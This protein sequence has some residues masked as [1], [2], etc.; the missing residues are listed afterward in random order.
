MAEIDYHA[1]A[2]RAWQYALANGEDTLEVMRE[3]GLRD[4]VVDQNDLMLDLDRD[5]PGVIGRAEFKKVLARTG[6]RYMADYLKKE[7]APRIRAISLAVNG[8]EAEVSDS[9]MERLSDAASGQE[10]FQFS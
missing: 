6:A 10:Y 8:R 1:T 5:V 7:L 2:E 4:L 3:T 9:S